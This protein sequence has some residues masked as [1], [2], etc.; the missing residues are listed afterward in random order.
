M[1][2]NKSDLEQGFM[3]PVVMMVIWLVFQFVH[4][5]ISQTVAIQQADFLDSERV[6]ARYAAV[7]A[8]DKVLANW[9][10]RSDESKWSW[11]EPSVEQAILVTLLPS[12]EPDAGQG[13]SGILQASATGKLGVRQTISVQIDLET[14]KKIKEVR[15]ET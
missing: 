15:D 4:A 1:L 6:K 5:Y 14:G 3:I 9:K 7:G 11:Q 10:E 8:I 2:R 12:S 13:Q